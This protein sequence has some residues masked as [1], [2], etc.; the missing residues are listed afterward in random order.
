MVAHSNT[1]VNPRAMVIEAFDAL[2]A[3]AAVSRSVCTNHLALRAKHGRLKLV[4]EALQ[5]YKVVLPKM[6]YLA[7]A[8]N[9]GSCMM[10]L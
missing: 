5:R 8:N 3:D 1:V 2:V 9:L 10:I 6:E 4:K 7:F